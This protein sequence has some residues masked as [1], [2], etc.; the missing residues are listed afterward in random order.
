MADQELGEDLRR[1]YERWWAALPA[2]D[3]DALDEILAD[4]WLYTDQFGTVREKADYI[5]L[6]E[7]TIRPG[8]STVVVDLDARQYG[9]IARA[10]GRY[11]VHGVIDGH[12]IDV[13]LRFTSL[14]SKREGHWRCH[15]QHTTE[16]REPLW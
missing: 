3:Y 2:H 11:D 9:P 6:V 10:V 13:K 14:W 16:I 8:H 4:D 5:A 15:A 7:R 12:D 1:E